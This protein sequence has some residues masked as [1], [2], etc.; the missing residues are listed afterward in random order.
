MV[1]GAEF[2]RG[3]MGSSG[4]SGIAELNKA[5]G[6]EATIEIKIKTLDSQ[7]YTLRV[8]KQVPVPALKDQIATVTGVI[9]EQQRLIC[10]GRVLKDDQLLSAYHVEDGHTLHMVVRQPVPPSADGSHNQ[11]AASP[12]TGASR[13]RS[14]SIVIEAV[15]MADQG[16]G[17]VPPEIG[18]IVSAVLGSFGFSNFGSG[19]DGVEHVLHRT[20]VASDEV[21]AQSQP[22]QTGRN[23]SDGLH[24]VFGVP[25]SVS[26]GPLS[27]PGIHDSLSTL[28][29]Y[30]SRLRRELDGD[31][32]QAA[33]MNRTEGESN[34]TGSGVGGLPTPA[35]LAQVMQ[36]AGQMLIEQAGDRLL[37]LARQLQEQANVTDTS[38]RT[39]TQTN[40]WMTGDQLINLGAFLLELGRATMTVRLGQFPSE[41]VVNA[42]P[43]VFISP[44][45]PSPLMVQPLPFQLGANYRGIPMGTGQPSSGS[46]SGLGSGF[47]PRRIDIQIRRGGSSATT[48]PNANQEGR[49]DSQQPSSQTNPTTVAPGTENPS[50]PTPAGV[51]VVPLRTMVAGIA[52]PRNQLP[53]D[54]AAANPMGFIPLLGR[55]ATAAQASSER[56]SG[57]LHSHGVQTEQQP[58]PVSAQNGENSTTATNAPTGSTQD[59]RPQTRGV[60]INILLSGARNNQESSESQIPSSAL[61]FLNSLFPGGEIQVEGVTN[62]SGSGAGFVPEAVSTPSGP[63]EAQQQPSGATEEGIVFSNLLRQIMP[64]ISQHVGSGEAQSTDIEMEQG[65]ASQAESSEAGTSRRPSDN[66]TNSPNPKRRKT[67]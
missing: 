5:E 4:A 50:I 64:V 6:S 55:L 24:G 51:R 3:E 38:I 27:P 7:T 45:G 31:H 8:D 39:N 33:S 48:Q 49:S 13:G 63:D 66:E 65:S 36:S 47:L 41:A 23:L 34:S 42:G 61:Q 44:S 52:A 20:S 56:A 11:P 30:L 32:T 58:A 62:M 16:D 40:A 28:S 15:N 2:N 54:S 59:S 25:D 43:A 21:D 35:A 57:E 29:Q 46:V 14:R 10:R 60:N 26:M 9:S 18:R 19:R 12:T 22:E 1:D 17:G 53:S 67:E 37:V